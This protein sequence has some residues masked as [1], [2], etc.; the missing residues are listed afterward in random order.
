MHCF[1]IT[2]VILSQDVQ[3]WRQ[4]EQQGYL[5]LLRLIQLC[6][7]F[8]HYVIVSLSW[9]TQDAQPPPDLTFLWH[10]GNIFSLWICAFQLEYLTVLSPSIC[11]M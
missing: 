11:Q 8:L 3:G 2:Q 4:A 9:S 10:H 5:M 7:I 6:M 1:Y